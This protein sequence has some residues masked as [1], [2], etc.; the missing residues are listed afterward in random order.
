VEHFG[1]MPPS[2]HR[3]RDLSAGGVRIDQAATLRVGATVLVTVG[4]LSAVGAT[5]VWVSDGWAGLKFAEEVNPDDARAKA[6]VAPRKIE[7][8]ARA[9]AAA[10]PTAGWM[11]NVTDPYRK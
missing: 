1:G 10:P 2:K 3:V 5:V 4:L 7:P 8:G 6:V 9:L 11:Q